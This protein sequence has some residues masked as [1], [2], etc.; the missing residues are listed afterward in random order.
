[1]E[2]M[3]KIVAATITTPKIHF[4]GVLITGERQ[5]KI[6]AIGPRTVSAR[7]RIHSGW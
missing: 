1:M 6:K 4:V 7:T 3:A 2:T 5:T